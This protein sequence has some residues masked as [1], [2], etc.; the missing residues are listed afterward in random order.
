M[1]KEVQEN[2]ELDIIDDYDSI[3]LVSPLENFPVKKYEVINET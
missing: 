3:A 1:C 2:L